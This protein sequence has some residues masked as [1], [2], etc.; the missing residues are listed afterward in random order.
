MSGQDPEPPIITSRQLDPEEAETQNVA[1]LEEAS[2]NATGMGGRR[3]S[4]NEQKY[5]QT[6]KLLSTPSKS[7]ASQGAGGDAAGT[8]STAGSN[9]KTPSFK[10][11]ARRVMLMQKLQQ[12]HAT[13]TTHSNGENN[14]N[15]QV[16]AASPRRSPRSYYASTKPPKRPYHHRKNKSSAADLLDQIMSP[17]ATGSSPSMGSPYKT[18][19][20]E[21]HHDTTIFASAGISVASSTTT[22]DSDSLQGQVIPEESSQDSDSDDD[23]EEEV[24]DRFANEILPLVVDT[25][26]GSIPPPPPDENSNALPRRRSSMAG[27]PTAIT[28]ST[29]TFWKRQ[30]RKWCPNFLRRCDILA[31]L[32]HVWHIVRNSYLVQLGLPLFIA[33]LGMYYGAGNPPWTFIPG[34]QHSA[35]LLNFLGRQV[36]TLELARLT[37]WLVLDCILLGSRHVAHWV[38][39][40]VTMTAVQSRG[41]PFV[42]ASWACWDMLILRGDSDFQMHWFFWTH[43]P[44]YSIANSGQYI[45]TSDLYMRFLLSMIAAGMATTAKRMFLTIRFGRRTLGTYSCS[46]TPPTTV[47]TSNSVFDFSFANEVLLNFLCSRFQTEIGKVA[48]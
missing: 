10:T 6:Y 13:S 37:Q 34:R 33:A 35:W 24:D 19:E 3:L 45:L 30:S 5:E 22:T 40:I 26:Y 9:L 31:F 28:K 15:D 4:I 42:V 32:Q 41:W 14:T 29:R 7:D 46:S 48:S 18:Y 2:R 27:A 25:E 47:Y 38:G 20:P 23:N 11:V 1:R 16:G 36:V 44:L 39:P 8:I 12:K 43:V 21:A 17:S